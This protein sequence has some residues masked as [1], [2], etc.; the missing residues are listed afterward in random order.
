MA[1]SRFK[2]KEMPGGL[3]LKCPA[4]GEV[5]YKKELEE[6]IKVCPKCDHHHTLN[7]MERVR[8]TLDEGTAQELVE[9]MEAIDRLNFEDKGKY[10]DK[11][12]ATMEKTK[13]MRG[14]LL[15]M[16]SMVPSRCLT[17]SQ[18]GS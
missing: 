1:W 7:G 18:A 11:L 17:S 4:C 8:F 14:S 12:A 16:L 2:K 15:L 3:W 10:T 9:N 6:N 5:I 13:R